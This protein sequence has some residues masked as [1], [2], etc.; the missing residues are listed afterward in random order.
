MSI[1]GHFDALDGF[2]VSG[3]GTITGDLTVS[4][5]K[6]SVQGDILSASN[7]EIDG[8]VKM[9]GQIVGPCLLNPTEVT[10]YTSNSI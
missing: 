1:D 4:S 6:I 5:G 2:N 7:L 3:N 8:D 9:G 10:L